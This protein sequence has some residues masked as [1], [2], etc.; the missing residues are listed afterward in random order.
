MNAPIIRPTAALD[1]YTCDV[2]ITWPGGGATRALAPYA[3]LAHGCLVYGDADDPDLE[4]YVSTSAFTR[5][6]IRKIPRRTDDA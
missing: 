3:H 2:I 5:C 6:D 1:G 4:H